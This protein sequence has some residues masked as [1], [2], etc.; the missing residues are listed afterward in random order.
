MVFVVRF[1]VIPQASV[2][3]YVV[4]VDTDTFLS[5]GGTVTLDSTSNLG[6]VGLGQLGPPLQPPGPRG[7]SGGGG[8]LTSHVEHCVCVF[9][10]SM[11]HVVEQ[12]TQFDASWHFAQPSRHGLQ[13]VVCWCRYV[14]PVQ[15]VVGW[16]PLVV[17][18]TDTG[19]GDR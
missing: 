7:G 6:P 8:G 17:A 16:S 18:G 2:L 1:F 19:D 11:K 13:V 5:V 4:F 3:S 14:P 10:A 12:S 9:A 15:V